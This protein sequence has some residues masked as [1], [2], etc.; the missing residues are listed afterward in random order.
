MNTIFFLSGA[1]QHMQNIIVW[2]IVGLA[3]IY[4]AIRFYRN[5]S[6]KTKGCCGECKS[7]GNDAA[8][9]PT[10]QPVPDKKDIKKTF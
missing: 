8:G 5:F 10:G 1:G 6:G 9:C 2:L 3:T 4:I 7:C